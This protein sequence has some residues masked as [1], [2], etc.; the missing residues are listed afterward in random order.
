M[1]GTELAPFDHFNA[2]LT[3]WKEELVEVLPRHI[4]L[5]TFITTARVAFRNTPALLQCRGIRQAITEAAQDGLLPD[6]REGVIIPYQGEAQWT[7]MI[8]GV[9]KVAKELADMIIDSQVVRDGDHFVWHQGDTPKIEHIPAPLG[10][11]QG[12]LIGVYAIFKVAGE[13]VHREVM[14]RDQVYAARNQNKNWQKSLLWSK[15]ETEGWRKVCIRRG[16]KTVPSV[17]ALERVISRDDRNYDFGPPRD[18]NVVP[19]RK[20]AVEVPPAPVE[21]GKLQEAPAEEPTPDGD[22]SPAPIEEPAPDAPEITPEPE[23]PKPANLR[24]QFAAAIAACETGSALNGVW[25]AFEKKFKA[26]A[27]R[28]WAADV[29]EKRFDQMTGG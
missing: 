6:G 24:E 1:T 29:F 22:T 28:D 12:D 10:K 21:G 25:A 4:P 8:Y 2:D 20:A 5:D 7:P 14:D 23:K 9:R 3:K 11:K 26:K 19:M 16:I 15:F 27:E 18:G 13:I 17:P